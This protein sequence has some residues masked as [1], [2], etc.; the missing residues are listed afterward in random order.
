MVQL[1]S[2]ILALAILTAPA[3]GVQT[4]HPFNR[5]ANVRNEGCVGVVTV[6]GCGIDSYSFINQFRHFTQ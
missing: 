4:P 1:R 2:N 5:H 3:I 6:V